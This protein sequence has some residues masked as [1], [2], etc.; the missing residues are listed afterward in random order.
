MRSTLS[1]LIFFAMVTL[2][3]CQ[4]KRPVIQVPVRTI[5]RKVTTLIPV[6]VPGDSATLRAYFEC[7]SLNNVLLKE[8]SE[9]KSN[10]ISTGHTFIN[11]VLDYKAK[12]NPDT[13]WIPNDTIYKSEQVPIEVEVPVVEIKM[14]TFQHVFF[15]IGL[16]VSGLILIWLILKLQ[17]VNILKL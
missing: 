4:S 7:D 2:F 8:I 3:G 6:R 13:V 5:E 16:I 12:T 11:G 9:H 14:S 15:I 1:I 10:N 17:K